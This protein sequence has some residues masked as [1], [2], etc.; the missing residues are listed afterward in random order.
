[1]REP[2]PGTVWSAGRLQRRGQYQAWIR[3]KA[4]LRRRAWWLTEWRGRYGNEPICVVCG[5]P[6]TLKSGDLHHRSYAHLG[7]ERFED[8]IPLDRGCHEALHQLWDRTPAWRALGREHATA[9][10]I[11]L[12][13]QH[14]PQQVAPDDE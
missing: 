5:R 8:L 4:W 1:M 2:Q 3:S 13:R 12:L 11:A 6:W 14:H 9:G 7:Q 10:L